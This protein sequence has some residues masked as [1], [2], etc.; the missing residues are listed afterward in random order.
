V[1]ERAQDHD[2]HEGLDWRITSKA[3]L[4]VP[5]FA[6]ADNLSQ[7]LKCVEKE[8][9]KCYQPVTP[10][11]ECRCLECGT[12]QELCSVAPSTKDKT[13]EADPPTKTSTRRAGERSRTATAA[14][15]KA[16]PK[17]T[18]ARRSP[19]GKGRAVPKKRSM[20]VVISGSRAA[21]RG[22]VAAQQHE[23]AAE[24]SSRLRTPSAISTRTTSQGE[25][26]FTELLGL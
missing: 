9:E 14:V 6:D 17:S 13:T 4:H 24:G 15:T 16:A 3:S 2:A 18:A 12:N 5:W 10:K 26:F 11:F 25:P 23:T 7:C 22:P 20:E 8:R 21:T 19:K 1:E